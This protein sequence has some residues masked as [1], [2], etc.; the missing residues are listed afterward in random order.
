MPRHTSAERGRAMAG[1]GGADRGGSR[2]GSVNK[3]LVSIR[4]AK[5]ER[6]KSSS[7][8]A[9]H[10][11]ES[12]G[13]H[14]PISHLV[15]PT[16]QLVVIPSAPCTHAQTRT[17]HSCNRHSQNVRK[18]VSTYIPRVHPRQSRGSQGE[19]CRRPARC[20]SRRRCTRQGMHRHAPQIA[21]ERAN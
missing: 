21:A 14:V 2:R 16:L 11:R 7:S 6:G 9:R 4:V 13:N 17:P 20:R 3:E 1:G 10:T 19:H 18:D 5:N 12:R 15:T 8:F